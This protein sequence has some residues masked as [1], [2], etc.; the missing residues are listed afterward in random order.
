[1]SRP[2][3]YQPELPPQ[4]IKALYHEAKLCEIPMTRLLAQIVT[5]ALDNTE[6]MRIAREERQATQTDAA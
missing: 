6:G 1:M 3:V 2:R 4:L 5:N